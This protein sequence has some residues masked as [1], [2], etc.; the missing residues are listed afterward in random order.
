MYLRKKSEQKK[1]E[2]NVQPYFHGLPHLMLLSITKRLS[3]H[4]IY[5]GVP[6]DPSGIQ[7]H[8]SSACKSRALTSRS[9]RPLLGNLI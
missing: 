2:G 3:V 7:A 4:F 6:L 1:H 8:D 5:L 9:P